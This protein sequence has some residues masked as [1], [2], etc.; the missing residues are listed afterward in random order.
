MIKAL[1]YTLLIGLLFSCSNG[2]KVQNGRFIQKRKYTK[3][4]YF[5]T[6]TKIVSESNETAKETAAKKPRFTLI[7]G[8]QVNK[9]ISTLAEPR[10]E[11]ET[12][13]G[14]KVNIKSESE[15]TP[16]NL[17]QN[18]STRISLAQNKEF[19]SDSKTSFKPFPWEVRNSIKI[20]LI[21]ALSLLGFAILLPFGL[22]FFKGTGL[23][24]LAFWFFTLMGIINLLFFI[25]LEIYWGIFLGILLILFAFVIMIKGYFIRKPPGF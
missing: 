23:H 24:F 15:P 10:V 17:D 21:V 5:S 22:L 20:G 12:E 7:N 13:V 6:K 8:T 4:F 1:A 9:N 18:E 14:S 19:H 16:V 25:T 2:N 3:G 11:L